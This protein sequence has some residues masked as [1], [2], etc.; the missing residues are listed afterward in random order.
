[1]SRRTKKPKEK[2]TKTYK[3]PYCT[4]EKTFTDLYPNLAFGRHKTMCKKKARTKEVT[5]RRRADREREK[6]VN[7][8]RGETISQKMKEYH[9]RRTTPSPPEIRPE[10]MPTNGEEELQR[11][12]DDMKTIQG[13]G[14]GMGIQP[15][16]K[17]IT[18]A[19]KIFGKIRRKNPQ[20]YF[21]PYAPPPEITQE[22]LYFLEETE[23]DQYDDIED[24]EQYTQMES[25]GSTMIQITEQEMT[26]KVE[27]RAKEILELQNRRMRAATTQNVPEGVLEE[28][29]LR[30]EKMGAIQEAVGIEP[31][32]GEE[33][34]TEDE[35]T[36]RAK[37]VQK[38]EKIADRGFAFTGVKSI[39]IQFNSF[40]QASKV[41]MQINKFEAIY[42][43]F[44]SYMQA[45]IEWSGGYGLNDNKKKTFLEEADRL[46]QLFQHLKGEARRRKEHADLRRF[47]DTYLFRRINQITWAVMMDTKDAREKD[48]HERLMRL[49]E[50]F[51]G[52]LGDYREVS[53]R[54]S[55]DGDDTAEDEDFWN[56]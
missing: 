55:V 9:R 31:E 20:V 44:H 39:T 15:E 41:F 16:S 43:M 5:E 34:L 6:K 35:L 1:M 3:C 30:E 52:D 50:G 14:D 10:S 26:E 38:A 49:S 25:S 23:D 27:R 47:V 46:D 22:K 17:I 24:E 56:I 53:Q 4:E 32:A 28:E 40:K 7:K 13:T 36:L 8:Q 18:G 12:I 48:E 11:I 51:S 42:M 54:V 29:L 2:I 33:E 19:K 37:Q 21:D 45:F